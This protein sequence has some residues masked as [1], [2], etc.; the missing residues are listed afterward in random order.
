MTKNITK[1]LT[2]EQLEQLKKF[3]Q[4]PPGKKAELLRQQ[5]VFCKIVKK[6]IETVRIYENDSLMAI[7]DINP[8]NIGH[9]LIFPKKHIQFL[10]QLDKDLLKDLFSLASRTSV[11][12]L[13]STKAQGINYYIAN[14]LAA[15]QRVPHLVLHLI[16]RFEGDGVSFEWQPKDVTKEELEKLAAVLKKYFEKSEKEKEKEE[17][18]KK[19]VEEFFK[20]ELKKF[21]RIA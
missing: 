14:G 2:P 17:E 12:L 11:Y 20:K 5:C 10:F 18:K 19:E 4:L 6:E 7:L 3:E 9:T 13:N 15:G 16:P 1:N 8:A 21:I